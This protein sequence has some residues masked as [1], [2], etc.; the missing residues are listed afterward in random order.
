MVKGVRVIIN[1]IINNENIIYIN[2][3][4]IKLFNWKLNVMFVILCKYIFFLGGG[5]R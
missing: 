3:S 5:K 1:K 4:K 2:I